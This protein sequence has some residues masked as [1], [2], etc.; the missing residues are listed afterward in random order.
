MRGGGEKGARGTKKGNQG[1]ESEEITNKTTDRKRYIFQRKKKG[2]RGGDISAKSKKKKGK[3][4]P[5][6]RE[7]LHL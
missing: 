2:A 6:P 3:G 1:G 5:P 4:N 7:N